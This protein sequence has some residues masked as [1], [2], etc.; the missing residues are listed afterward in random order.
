MKVLISGGS[1]LIGKEISRQLLSKGY[2]VAHLSRRGTSSMKNIAAY[3]WDVDKAT[4]DEQAFMWQPDYLINL[5][6]API[7]NRWTP[8]YK[9]EILRSRVD[10]TRLLFQAVQKHMVPLKAFVSASAVGYYPHSYTANYTETSK[11]G[12]DF[13]S[14]V[15]VAWEREAEQFKALNIRTALCRVGIVLS[16]AGGALPQIAKPIRYGLGAPLARGTQWMPWIHLEDVARVFIEA[17]E[18]PAATGPINAVGP[19]NITNETLTK[20]CAHVLNKPLFLPNIPAFALKLLLGEMAE[21]AL[22][23]NKVENTRLQTLG[24]NYRFSTLEAALQDLLQ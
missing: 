5:A 10:G 2:Q 1:G 24:F 12:N 19:Y 20:A 15:C 3:A 23:S 18:N 16:D 8:T 6:G 11:P 21:T 9:S 14:E 4:Y 17:M 22:S 7:D 13:L